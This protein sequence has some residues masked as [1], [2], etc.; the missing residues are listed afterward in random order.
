MDISQQINYQISG[1]AQG[2]KVV[3]L[4]GIMGSLSNWSRIKGVFESDYQVLVLDQRGHGHSF[5]APTPYTLENY[6][7]DLRQLL[8]VLSWPQINLIGHS[9][10]GRVAL[11]FADK[12]PQRLDRL[13]I[14]D[15]SP[16]LMST[17]TMRIRTW[18]DSVP[19]P[20]PTRA[21]AKSFLFG[22]FL[23][24]FATVAEGTAMAHFFFMNIIETENRGVTWRFDVAGIH[25]TLVEGLRT[26]RWREWQNLKMPTLLVRGGR[27]QDL[28]PVDFQ[29]MQEQ[30]PAVEAV[31]VPDAGHWVH[32]DQ[33]EAFK[34]IV[35]SFVAGGQ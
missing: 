3:F 34:R 13:V 29:K 17:A 1:E 35:R 6:A 8:D 20:F 18:V 10:G 2:K 15:V 27:S 19:V 32:F 24:Q 31:E 23:Q 5:H 12:Y 25:Q 14:E 28:T 16:A 11:V 9:M 7:E 21:A 33:P 4:H 26:D 22:P 30:N